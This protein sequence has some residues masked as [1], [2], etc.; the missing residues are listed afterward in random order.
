[1][2]PQRPPLRA[3]DILAAFNTREVRYVLIGAF[4]AIAQ[5]ASIE[6]TYDIDVTPRR[7]PVNLERLSL[8]L[9]D[10]DARIRVDDL[11][12]GLPFSHDALS[13]A[14]MD[15]LN[16]TCLVLPATIDGDDGD[17]LGGDERRLLVFIEDGVNAGADG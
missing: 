13:L 2:S 1:V 5:G 9:D 10:L 6:A 16:L 12:E 11:E 8:A 4:A 7:D 14:R 3:E 17:T 15:M